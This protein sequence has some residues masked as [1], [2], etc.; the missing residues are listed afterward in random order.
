VETKLCGHVRRR[1]FV[2]MGRALAA[3]KKDG[4]R[5]TLWR[6][7]L[8]TVNR[9]V[10]FKI[11]VGVWVETPDR[12]FCECDKRFTAA[13]LSESAIRRFA[14]DPE[15]AL[16]SEF[17]DEALLKGDAC[18][19]ITDGPVLASYG[20]YSVQPT[21]ID[22][23][24]LFLEFD[25]DYVYMYKGFTH[26]RYRGKRL[27]AVGMTLALAHY[28]SKGFKGIVSYIESDNFESLKSSYRMGYL[29]FGSICL[30]Q[31]FGRTLSYATV[32]C[33]KFGFS[34]IHPASASVAVCARSQRS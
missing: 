34:V 2:G 12:S 15:N 17:V 33:K 8:K 24:E 16:S 4:W 20:W 25:K 19:G 21:R 30:G 14:L 26:P 10:G 7:A 5:R 23:P 32:G 31:L 29:R 3:I 13:F 9:V 27:H 6:T 11:L 1:E 28:R 18:F 22:P